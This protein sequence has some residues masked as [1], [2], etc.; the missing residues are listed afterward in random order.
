MELARVAPSR[1]A[2]FR[3]RSLMTLMLGHFTVDCYA[4]LL[5]V[6]YPLLIQRF[7]LDLK[8]VG[9]V[10]LA[11]TGTASVVQ[12][13]FGWVADRTGTRF[14]GLALIWTATAFAAI[15][16]APSFPILLL[17]AALAGLGSGAYHPF[18]AL[19]AGAVIADRE[20]NTAMSVYVT[21][22]TVGVALGP[23]LG[24]LFFGVLGTRGTLLA[25]LP[26]AS[27]AIWLLY[28][29]GSTAGRLRGVAG[30]A[31]EAATPIPVG[32]MVIVLGVMM[33]RAW[34]TSGLQAFIPSWYASLGYPSTFYGPLA[35]T[36]ILASAIG[37]VGAGTLADRFG[38]R[39]VI[40]GSLVLTAPALLLVA[41]F[42]GPIAFLTLAIVGLS[43]AS[44]GPL[45]LVLAQQLMRGRAGVASGLVLGLGFVT[46]AIGIPITGAIADAYGMETAIRAQ[47][48]LVAATFA[49]AWFL[50]G[51][52]RLRALAARSRTVESRSDGVPS[53][54]TS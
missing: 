26:G 10:S 8:T 12:P 34:T 49:L 48:L 4:G 53:I 16:F 29:L 50:P 46:G 25:F 39:Q 18:G 3:N 21:G 24:I 45:L 19:N 28:Q 27:I 51:E 9:L 23:L 44:S 54:P 52:A 38:R 32:P 47:V 5:P 22:G 37:T 35:T 6:L 31:R 33:S 11:Y 7:T 20:R 36:L 15:G 2:V 40:L 17:L 14:I 42:T 41:Q 1:L 13:L 43:A 30:R